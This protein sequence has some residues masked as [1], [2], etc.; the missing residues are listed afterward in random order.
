MLTPIFIFQ[1][2]SVLTT[3]MFLKLCDLI[4]AKLSLVTQDGWFSLCVLDQS[5]LPGHTILRQSFQTLSSFTSSRCQ[6]HAQCHRTHWTC[7]SPLT[8]HHV[9][10][11]TR[12]VSAQ[13]NPLW[14]RAFIRHAPEKSAQTPAN[15]PC[16]APDC[17][18]GYSTSLGASRRERRRWMEISSQASSPLHSAPG[19]GDE[20]EEEEEGHWL[21]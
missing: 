11:S 2:H 8:A 5:W 3:S 19:P 7:K 10:G 15:D 13:S 18:W 4:R 21:E 14:K 20:E 9:M 12:V 16:P 17:I 1:L 6:T